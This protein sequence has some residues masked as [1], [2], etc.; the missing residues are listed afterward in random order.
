M[1]IFTFQKRLR[2]ATSV[3]LALTMLITAVCVLPTTPVAAESNVEKRDDYQEKAN[4]LKKEIEK[5]EAEKAET[6]KIRDKVQ[7]Q[8]DNTEAQIMAVSEKLDVIE[9]ELADVQAELDEVNAELEQNKDI[10]KQRLRAIYMTGASSNDLMVLMGADDV[11]DYLSMT[12]LSKSVSRH[13]EQLIEEIVEAVAKVEEDYA[14]VEEKKL[15]QD[16]VKRELSD[17]MNELGEQVEKLENLIDASDTKID[18]AQSELDEYNAAIDELNEKIAEASRESYNANIQYNGGQF[19]WPCPG[20]YYISSSYGWRWG[21]MHN[22]VDIAGSGIMGKPIVAAADGVVYVAE[23]NSGGYGN[24]VMINHGSGYVTV[25]G[26]MTRYIVSAGQS[27]SAGQ[28]IGYVGSTGRSTGPHLHFE[29]RSGGSAQ[30]P[31]NY[32]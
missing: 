28:T 5:L 27:V 12:E 32:F 25:Y 24:Y 16:A 6:E 3:I 2:Q 21:R 9:A 4:A 1:D 7:E 11:A 10:F 8:V 31:M 29:I 15:E 23:Y 14:I 19:V 30:N 13:D 26:H 20:Y 22:G 17:A 18:E